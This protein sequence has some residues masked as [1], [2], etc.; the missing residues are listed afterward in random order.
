[1][2]MFII[3]SLSWRTFR[4]TEAV[5]MHMNKIKNQN[6]I[7]KTWWKFS[8]ISFTGKAELTIC[9]C[10]CTSLHF[11]WL[12]HSHATIRDSID[13]LAGYSE[14]NGVAWNRSFYFFSASFICEPLWFTDVSLC[15]RTK[16][17]GEYCYFGTRWLPERNYTSRLSRVFFKEVQKAGGSVRRDYKCSRSWILA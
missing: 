17:H 2:S 3:E 8:E 14:I 10:S 12:H 7:W 1:M 11:I 13:V 9:R 16:L 15:W 5:E 6:S 4:V